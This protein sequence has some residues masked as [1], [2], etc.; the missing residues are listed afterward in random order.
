MFFN[1][2]GVQLL[3]R[4]PRVKTSTSSLLSS[5]DLTTLA[6]SCSSLRQAFIVSTIFNLHFTSSSFQFGN[7]LSVG[8]HPCWSAL[9]QRLFK[10]KPLQPM[11]SPILRP[12]ALAENLFHTRSRTP[13]ALHGFSK[14]QTKFS[15]EFFLM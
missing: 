15:S 1:Y 11:S 4:I 8:W 5:R 3:R 10:S 7:Q 14:S 6:A 12:I 9:W 2:N 13:R